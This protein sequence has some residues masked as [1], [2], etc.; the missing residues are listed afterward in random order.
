MFLFF[1]TTMDFNVLRSPTGWWFEHL[2]GDHYG[3][4]NYCLSLCPFGR[5]A[6]LVLLY[7]CFNLSVS[8]L[9]VRHYIKIPQLYVN[10][11]LFIAF[12][13]FFS[14]MNMNALVYLIALIAILIVRHYVNRIFI[15][16]F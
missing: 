3:L 10:I 9:I 12:V 5:V 13:L 1:K 14:L 8:I 4:H 16:I 7:F 15:L 2:V 6:D 11:T